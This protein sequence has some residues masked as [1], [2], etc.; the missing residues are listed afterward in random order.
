MLLKTLLIDTC[1]NKMLENF[2]ILRTVTIDEN[3]K[4]FCLNP[5][6][7][8]ST[9]RLPRLLDFISRTMAPSSTQDAPERRFS[10]LGSS[11]P[12]AG[13]KAY[14]LLVFLV[15]HYNIFRWLLS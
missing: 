5:R 1:S 12:H 4:L 9:G 2:Q 7:K 3:F 8:R 14:N 13:E 10:Q 6:D 15:K 11:I